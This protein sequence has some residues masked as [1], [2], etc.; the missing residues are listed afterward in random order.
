MRPSPET[1]ARSAASAEATFAQVRPFAAA[2]VGE[3]P[4]QADPNKRQEDGNNER[5]HEQIILLNDE[6]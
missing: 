3:Q 2:T 6:G 4:N 1:R 5:V